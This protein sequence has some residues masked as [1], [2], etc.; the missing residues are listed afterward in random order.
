MKSPFPG[1]D[2]YVEQYWGD[3]HSRLV[4]YACDQIND[5]LP[6]K[7]IASVEERLVVES[8]EEDERSI[9]PDVRVAE[10]AAIREGGIGVAEAAAAT[11]P[12]TVHYS[13]EPA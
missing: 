3:F 10:Q 9:Y 8:G 4:L 13:S 12:I 7:L 1:M 11:Q 2:P 6:R 5:Q